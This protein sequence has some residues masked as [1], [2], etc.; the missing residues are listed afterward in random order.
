[1]KNRNLKH[2]KVAGGRFNVQCF[3]KD[4]KLKWT[5]EMPNG[6]VDVGIEYLLDGGFNGG[7]QISTWY[8]GLINN[9]GF[10]A[11]AAADTASSHAG[12]V[13]SAAYA[14]ASRPEWTAD[15]AATRAVTNSTTVDFSMNATVTIKGIFIISNSTKSGTTGTLWSTA[16]FS[17]NA[18]VTNGDT[19]K[20]T[21]TVSG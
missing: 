10:S 14:E 4:G 18:S 17:S 1:M 8:M 6:I 3:D 11:L 21:Y 13:E 19:L 7:A 15:A 5:Q 2:S 16:A 20:V 12:W 9:S